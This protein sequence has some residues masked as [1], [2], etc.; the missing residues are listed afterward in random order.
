MH[1]NR[2]SSSILQHSSTS[3][4]QNIESTLHFTSNFNDQ[5]EVTQEVEAV[6]VKTNVEMIREEI[7]LAGPKDYCE[8][9]DL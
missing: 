3:I 5:L 2:E 7:F 9:Q 4:N 6:I 8:T 1:S